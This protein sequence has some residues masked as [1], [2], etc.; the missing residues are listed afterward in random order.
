MSNGSPQAKYAV[1][2]CGRPSVET[3]AI[4]HSVEA[5]SSEMVTDARR[6]AETGRA[7]RST[8]TDAA[9]V[10]LHR[11]L[12]EAEEVAVDDRLGRFLPVQAR[13][14][15]HEE[16][17]EVIHGRVREAHGRRAPFVVDQGVDVTLRQRLGAPQV[18][19]FRPGGRRRVGP[20]VLDE[21]QA[22]RHEAATHD[23][24]ALVAQRGE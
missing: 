23:E 1:L 2:T 4:A 12:G 8:F 17:N 9:L 19:L 18:E 13:A 14:E 11:P 5:R 22:V 7:G 3:V 20:E 24:N 10:E 16:R 21:R 15:R 6:T